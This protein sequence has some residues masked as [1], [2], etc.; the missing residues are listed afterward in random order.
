MEPFFVPMIELTIESGVGNSDDEAPMI[1]LQ[2]S[3]DGGKTWDYERARAIG[4]IGRYSQRAIWRRN[5][6]CSRFDVYRIA[7]SAAVK[8]VILQMTADI[9]GADDAAA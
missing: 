7:M 9:Q 4:A 2:I 8:P 3:R 1:R 5:G 6:R